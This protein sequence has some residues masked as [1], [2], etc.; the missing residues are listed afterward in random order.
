MAHLDP[1]TNRLVVRI[2]CP[3]DPPRARRADF[4]RLHRLL[5]ASRRGPIV[6][7]EVT[8]VG[9]CFDWFAFEA[10]AVAGRRI[11][12]QAIAAPET[13]SAAI[14]RAVLARA[15]DATVEWDP[16]PLGGAL[17]DDRV[18]RAFIDAV[19]EAAA[20]AERLLVAEEETPLPLLSG[21]DD[22]LVAL[23]TAPFVQSVSTS[24]VPPPAWPPDTFSGGS[25]IAHRGFAELRAAIAGGAALVEEIGGCFRLEARSG[26]LARVVEA[27]PELAAAGREGISAWCDALER[28]LGP[29][30]PDGVFHLC[31]TDGDR[32][33][34]WRCMRRASHLVPAVHGARRRGDRVGVE[35][36]LQQFL[37]A[38]R[39]LRTTARAGQVVPGPAPVHFAL[40]R[41]SLVYVG[42]IP[43][44]LATWDD[45]TLRAAWRTLVPAVEDAAL[46]RQLGDQ[47]D[48]GPPRSAAP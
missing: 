6:H 14:R 27:P 16:E 9:L 35:R 23:R 20:R 12:A 38:T 11:T 15:A 47:R 33:W 37:A 46:L 26:L 31:S 45:A 13:R 17:A 3:T 42:P 48:G 44:R 21:V 30:R 28:A 1:L 32:V 39:A 36:L 29:L 5:P 43:A 4:D 7:G 34:V 25:A 24:S 8:D 22:L 2:L 10:G 19:R 41:G 40:R 18:L